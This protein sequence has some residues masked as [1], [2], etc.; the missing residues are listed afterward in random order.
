VEL[1]ELLSTV[2]EHL[3]KGEVMQMQ[4]AL[5]SEAAATAAFDM[6]LRKTYY[7]TGSL[8][9]NSCKAAPMLGG[10]P[11]PLV[12]A[13]FAYGKHVGMAFQLVDD[14]LD[15]HGTASSLGKPALN[16]L[17]QGLATAPVLFA[18]QSQPA[19]LELIARKFEAPGDVEAAV[20]LV[21]T[22][23]GAD[24]TRALAI[25]HGNM[26]LEALEQVEDSEFR[27]ALAALVHRIIHR[28]H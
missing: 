10:Y 28:D 14:L 20:D 17:K 11:Q 16:D 7:K 19:A 18:S 3:V 22:S 27:T 2:I 23:G 26:A 12:D 25:A 8:I 6:Y 15:Y 21:A 24:Q 1:V 4:S 5:R 13:M 9:A